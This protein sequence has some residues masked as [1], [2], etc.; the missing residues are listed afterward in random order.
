MLPSGPGLLRVRKL[1]GA[2][3]VLGALRL[4][5]GHLAPPPVV[6]SAAGPA[7]LMAAGVMVRFRSGDSVGQVLQAF[8][9]LLVNRRPRADLP[10]IGPSAERSATPARTVGSRP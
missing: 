6:P 9:M 8:A 1:T 2:L 10:L 4:L 5:A 3:E 7:L